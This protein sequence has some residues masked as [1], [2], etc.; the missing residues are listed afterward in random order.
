MGRFP[1]VLKLDVDMASEHAPTLLPVLPLRDVVV[2]PNMVIP[3]FVGREK[4][5]R[6]L[7]T[8]L[9]GE[10][11]IVLITQKSPDTAD[12]AP[13]DL[14]PVGTL[15][16]VLQLLKLPDGTIKVL[17][18]GIE[19]VRVDAL[20]EDEGML[21]ASGEVLDTSNARAARDRGDGALGDGTVRAVH[22]DQPQT[23]ARTDAD[24]GRD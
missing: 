20:H 12:P 16:Q 18:E 8:A 2:F 24:P 1:V 9:E 15:A 3:L 14:Y 23:A 11:R 13:D 22:Q 17:I 6:A 4:S 21:F 19:R 10:H 5:I 7:N